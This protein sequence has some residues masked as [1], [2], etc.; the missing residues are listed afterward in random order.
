MGCLGAGSF[1]GIVGDWLVDEVCWLLACEVGDCATRLF[2][3]RVRYSKIVAK[4]L[5]GI[6]GAS[7]KR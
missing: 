4:D 1:A 7:M 3:E 2:V 6:A 5:P